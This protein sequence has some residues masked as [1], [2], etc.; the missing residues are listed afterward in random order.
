M[1][2]SLFATDYE[3]VL[4]AARIESSPNV[5]FSC[6]IAFPPSGVKR[7]RQQFH[8]QRISCAFA[9]AR[10]NNMTAPAQLLAERLAASCE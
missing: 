6:K 3:A 5:A 2:P 9:V 1:L 8:I 7:T 4:S 10:F